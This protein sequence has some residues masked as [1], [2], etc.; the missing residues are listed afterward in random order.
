MTAQP[1]DPSDPEDAWQMR[2]ANAVEFFILALL[3]LHNTNPWPDDFPAVDA[4]MLD[5][6]TRLWEKGFSQTEIRRAYE[7]AL[8]GLVS[9]AAGDEIRR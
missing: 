4:A 2:F 8:S 1:V 9:F 3:D 7:A 5:L 6:A